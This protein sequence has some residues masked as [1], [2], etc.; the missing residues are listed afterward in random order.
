[1]YYL[2][3]YFAY[4]CIFLVLE[5]ILIEKHIFLHILLFFLKNIGRILASYF[6]YFKR[7]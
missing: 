3:N 7:I 6:H 1:L 2:L 5:N 4:K